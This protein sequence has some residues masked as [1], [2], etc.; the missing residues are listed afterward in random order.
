MTTNCTVAG[1]IPEEEDVRESGIADCNGPFVFAPTLLALAVLPLVVLLLWC[2]RR[3]CRDHLSFLC[4]AAIEVA[5]VA[6]STSA[7]M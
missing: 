1:E 6:A 7:A 3:W 5:V 4:S 2:A